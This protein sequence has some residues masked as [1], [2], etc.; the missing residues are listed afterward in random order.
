MTLLDNLAGDW[1]FEDVTMKNDRP[2]RLFRSEK[3]SITISIERFD[4]AIWLIEGRKDG[5]KDPIIPERRFVCC[6][7]AMLY[8]IGVTTKYD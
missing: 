2:T 7:D 5:E 6:E 8:L 1:M 3:H 4:E